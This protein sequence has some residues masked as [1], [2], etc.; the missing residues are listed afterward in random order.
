MPEDV[1]YMKVDESMYQKK[2]FAS[3]SPEFA[4]N[5]YNNCDEDCEEDDQDCPISYSYPVS[6]TPSV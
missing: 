3:M 5:P 4:E 6:I 2:L 1:F